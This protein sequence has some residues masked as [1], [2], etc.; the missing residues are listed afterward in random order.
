MRSL[1]LH[2]WPV[3]ILLM[4]TGTVTA[5]DRE[6]S[7]GTVGIKGMTVLFMSDLQPES[8]NSEIVDWMS[9]SSEDVIHRVLY[10]KARSLNFGYDLR[11]EP[12]EGSTKIM[13]SVGPIS[14]SAMSRV[15]DDLG[16]MGKPVPEP[17]D[18][19]RYPAPQVVEE[20]EAFSLEIAVNR[21]TGV[22]LVDL[23]M[24]SRDPLK[25]QQFAEDQYPARE[26]TIDDVHMM[27]STKELLLNGDPIPK[28]GG[29]VSGPI[30]FFTIPDRGRYLLS[31]RPH[32]GYAFRKAGVILV[33][34]MTFTIDGDR[35]E[36]VSTKPV[37][38]DGGKWDLWV[39]HEPDYQ[40]SGW[41]LGAM[42]LPPRSANP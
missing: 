34:K 33:N 1:T 38:G 4:S 21:R 14:P 2:F 29:T 18:I 26:F 42:G 41:L 3:V 31:F 10:D 5:Q 16:R 23:L 39:L 12:I 15:R 6:G 13:I 28:M 9:S 7:W 30:L 40:A 36:L 17:S 22:K 11:L 25:I 37:M 32:E 8:S 19:L 20:G 35:F 24:V 27:L